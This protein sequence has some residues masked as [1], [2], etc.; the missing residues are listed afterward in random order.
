MLSKYFKE[1]E[2]QN[3]IKKN[4]ELTVV[5]QYT[6]YEKIINYNYTIKELKEITTKLKLLKHTYTKKADIRQYCT[7]MMYLSNNMTKIQKC[8]RN[9]FIRLFNQT[10]GPSYKNHKLSN[11]IDDFL[12]TENIENIDYYYYFSFKD[13]DNFIYTFNIISLYSLITRNIIKNPYNRNKFTDSII[14]LLF[15]RM[16]Y[17]RILNQ[18]S[19]FINYQ[20]MVQNMNDKIQNIFHK[21]DE[22]GNYTDSAWFLDLDHKQLHKFIYEIYEI[23]CYRAQL[24]VEMKQIICPPMGNPFINMPRNIILP[25]NQQN[26]FFFSKG[27]LKRI[28]LDIM[29]KLV[30]S[31]H[32]DE[33]KNL[34]ALY[35]LSALTLVSQNACDALPWLYASVYYN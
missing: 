32:T 13:S 20:P 22:L 29:E 31:A 11:N 7:N 27:N 17:N 4:R 33:N 8:W 1:F 3:L 28:A 26:S 18:L 35:I 21:I 12:T 15:K 34:G 5:N 30:Y 16:R 23:W 24:S 10:L 14:T 25:Q 9:Y 19:D 6:D 2:Y